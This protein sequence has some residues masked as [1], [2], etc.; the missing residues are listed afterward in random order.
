MLK[1]LATGNHYEPA[2]AYAGISYQTFRNWLQRGEATT[3]GEYFEFFESV[4]RAIAQAEIASVTKIKAAEKE[5][6]RAAAWMLERRHPDRW[7]STQR[8][9]LEVE[10]EMEKALDTLESKL[11]P[12]IFDQ[13]LAALTDEIGGEATEGEAP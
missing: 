12:A 7:A 2:C 13:V 10:K 3:R 4:Q 11:P 1:A 5:D 6:W 8:I 9:R